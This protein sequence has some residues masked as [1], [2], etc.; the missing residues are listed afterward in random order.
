M[1]DVMPSGLERDAGSNSEE[2]VKHFIIFC[3]NFTQLLMVKDSADLLFFFSPFG[4][5]PGSFG[6]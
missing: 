6:L 4:E 5:E 2:S 1:A 3:L